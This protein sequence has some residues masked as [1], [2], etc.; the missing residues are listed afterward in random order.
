[1]KTFIVG[2]LSKVEPVE[3]KSNYKQQRIEISIQEFDSQTGQPKELQVFPA[4]IFNKKID[5]LK[6]EQYQG[7]RV[8]ADCFL[9]SLKSEKDGRTFYNIALNVNKLDL[10]F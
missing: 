2:T 8:K 9:K 1:M 10:P 5:E 6:A 4:T 7:L 3:V